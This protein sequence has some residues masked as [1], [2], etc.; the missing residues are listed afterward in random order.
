M[1]RFKFLII[2]ILALGLGMASSSAAQAHWGWGGCP[3]PVYRTHYSAGFGPAWGGYAR[4][5]FYGP[6][7]FVGPQFHPGFYPARRVVVPGAF[8]PAWTPGFGP[9]FRSGTMMRIGF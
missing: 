6:R 8:G 4:S 7:V 3:T 1:F 9:G 2:A 5:S